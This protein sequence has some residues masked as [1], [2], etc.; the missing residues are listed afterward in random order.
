MMNHESR[1]MKTNPSETL[2]HLSVFILLFCVDES[3]Q[4]RAR[5]RFFSPF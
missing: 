5:P 3:F 2:F 1:K 4:R